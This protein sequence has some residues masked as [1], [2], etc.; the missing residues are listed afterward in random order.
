MYKSL[1]LQRVSEVVIK[2]TYYVGW[3][4]A[5]YKKNDMQTSCNMSEKVL[6]SAVAC[7]TRFIFLKILAICGNKKHQSTN[8][9]KSLNKQL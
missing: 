6:D 7:Q 9:F 8:C 5:Y 1:S 2:H 4:N 3:E